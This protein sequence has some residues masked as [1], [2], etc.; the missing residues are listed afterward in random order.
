M[1]GKKHLN[2]HLMF[3]IFLF[4]LFHVLLIND[5]PFVFTAKEAAKM[6]QKKRQVC[7]AF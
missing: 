2:P 3:F 6:E 1:N 5:Y 7:T 4:W